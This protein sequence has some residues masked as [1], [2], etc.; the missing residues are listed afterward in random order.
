MP[1]GAAGETVLFDEDDVAPAELREVPRHGG[2]GDTAADDE[3]TRAGG[4]RSAHEGGEL[5][6]RIEDSSV[7]I[8]SG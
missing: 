2:S 6:F 4:E 1:A 5:G 3:D 8:G 7:P